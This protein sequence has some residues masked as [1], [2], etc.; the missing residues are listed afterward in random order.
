MLKV[1]GAHPNV[2]TMQAF[3]EDQDA[4]YIV[5]EMCQGGEL[6]HRL[7]DK[8]QLLVIASPFV[9]NMPGSLWH[10]IAVP[11]TWF[12]ACPVRG[13]GVFLAP[14]ALVGGCDMLTCAEWVMLT[15]RTF[16]LWPLVAPSVFDCC[17][18]QGRYSEGQAARIMAEVAEAVGFLHRK[19]IVHFDL[20]RALCTMACLSD[21]IIHEIRCV[22]DRLV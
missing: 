13:S 2:V 15:P 8:V 21:V 11:G 16:P 3:F 4:F 1:A 14:R 6:Y 17:F 5:M 12:V 19:G 18:W 9:H 20:V 7:A 22:Q 10:F